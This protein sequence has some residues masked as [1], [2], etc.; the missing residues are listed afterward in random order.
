MTDEIR[1]AMPSAPHTLT[2]FDLAA[3][4]EIRTFAGHTDRGE[5]AAFSPGRAKFI[6]RHA[7]LSN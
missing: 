1:Y 2:L 5:W 3:G 7:D 4:K 6:R